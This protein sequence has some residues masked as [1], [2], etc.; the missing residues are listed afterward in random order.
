MKKL[1]IGT[2]VTVLGLT[3]CFG[4]S[5]KAAENQCLQRVIVL[6]GNQTVD[7][8]DTDC[9]KILGNCQEN[10]NYNIA[11]ICEKLGQCDISG[12]QNILCGNQKPENQ[13]PE[14]QQPE[15]QKPENQKP[16]Q[17]DKT[18]ARQVADLV[19]EERAKAG[20]EAVTVDEKIESAA[21]VRAKEIEL[22]FSH[23]RPDGRSFSTVLT[24]NG[25]SFQSS[26]ENIAWGQSSPEEVMNGW[27]NS[28]GHRANIL[29]PDFKKI[30]VGFYQNQAG[31]KFWT[32]LFVK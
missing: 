32:Q 26:G 31:R 10:G 5:A 29:N 18:F 21:L 20:L 2:A 28:S 15:N 22:S 24:E 23:T 19:N 7:C 13:K 17:A 6:N 4:M 30:G 8:Q 9:Q 27:M 3:G 25:I 11:D 16:E 12:I 14:N 1:L